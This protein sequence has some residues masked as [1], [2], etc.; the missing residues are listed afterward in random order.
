MAHPRIGLN[1]LR[2][3]T[4]PSCSSTCSSIVLT[5]LCWHALLSPCGSP[6]KSELKH[7]EIV[8]KALNCSDIRTLYQDMQISLRIGDG[9]VRTVYL[10]RLV[11]TLVLLSDI[12]SGGEGLP[13]GQSSSPG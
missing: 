10:S 7:V 6:E 12:V 4:R 1:P 2:S 5:T 11:G 13:R 9:W 8:T 3:T